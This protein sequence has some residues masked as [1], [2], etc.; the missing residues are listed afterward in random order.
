VSHGIEPL[1][2]HQLSSYAAFKKSRLFH[3]QRRELHPSCWKK[4]VASNSAARVVALHAVPNVSIMLIRMHSTL[5]HRERSKDPVVQCLIGHHHLSIQA[6]VCRISVFCDPHN[7]TARVHPTL[8]RNTTSSLKVLALVGRINPVQFTPVN[9]QTHTT[10]FITHSHA[11][12]ANTFFFHGST[13]PV[14]QDLLIFEV[15]RLH[16]DTPH[17]VE[18]LWTSDRPL[19]ETST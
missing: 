7:H 15:S 14:G 4:A 6:R 11:H 13:A 16:S 9:T 12:A 19:A 17:S 2:P 5:C 3:F 8:T 18:V 1:K 10:Q